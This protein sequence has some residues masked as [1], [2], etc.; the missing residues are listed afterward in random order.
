VSRGSEAL[1]EERR[2]R[3][4]KCGSEAEGGSIGSGERLGAAERAAF[5]RF[6]SLLTRGK[7]GG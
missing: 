2:P 7:E 5:K 1:L 3:T 6:L 4:A